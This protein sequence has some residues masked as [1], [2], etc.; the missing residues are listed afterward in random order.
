[1]KTLIYA[2][3]GASGYAPENTMSAFKKSLE[4]KADGI[5]LDVQLTNDGQVVVIHDYT[6]DRT[7][8]G[9][10]YVRNMSLS[11]LKQLD[12][13]SWFSPEF[14]EER[15]P[16]LEEVL[17]Y[18]QNEDIIINIEIKGTPGEYI[19]GIDKKVIEVV[20][21]FGMEQKVIISSF[22]HNILIQC[23]AISPEIK[24]GLLYSGL[25][26]ETGWYA[27]MVGA[28]AVHPAYSYI[29]E[30]M[31]KQCKHY[32]IHINTWTVNKEENVKSLCKAGVEGIITNYP[33]MAVKVRNETTL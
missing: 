21:Q 15:I 16:T 12:F 26:A 13:G 9:K 19:T 3:R 6:V 18:F 22:N 33:D 24:I 1:M 2:H 11:E 14:K 17:Q 4:M 28:N 23:K 29:D 31:L 30:L 7:S 27:Y 32:G 8:N 10:G 20:K 25:L 5:E